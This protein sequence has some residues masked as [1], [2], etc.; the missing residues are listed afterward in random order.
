[1]RIII[2]KDVLTGKAYRQAKNNM[3]GDK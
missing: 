3:K 2:C 1:M